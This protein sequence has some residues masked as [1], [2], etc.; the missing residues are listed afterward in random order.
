MTGPGPAGPR[1]PA[2]TSRHRVRA[3]RLL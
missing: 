2:R 1:R 3:G